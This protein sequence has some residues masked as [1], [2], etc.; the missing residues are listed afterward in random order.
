MV[1]GQRIGGEPCFHLGPFLTV[2]DKIKLFKTMGGNWGG[3]DG[4]GK[5]GGGNYGWHDVSKCKFGNKG[6]IKQF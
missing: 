6:G 4:W 2:P 1:E 3:G 5:R